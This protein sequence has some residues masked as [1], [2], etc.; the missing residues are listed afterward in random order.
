MIDKGISVV[1]DEGMV[2]TREGSVCEM[3]GHDDLTVESC[4]HDGPFVALDGVDL[5]HHKLGHPRVVS[6]LLSRGCV[7]WLV[8][9]NRV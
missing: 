7:E 6:S 3:Y 5:L 8:V 1:M 2:V 9:G 4:G